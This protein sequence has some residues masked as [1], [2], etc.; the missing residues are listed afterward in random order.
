MAK[1]DKYAGLPAEVKAKMEKRDAAAV[2]GQGV[3]SAVNRLREDAL[4]KMVDPA[5]NVDLYTRGLAIVAAFN[6]FSDATGAGL[7]LTPPVGT[8]ASKKSKPDGDDSAAAT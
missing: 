7:K 8:K 6:E 1:F 2:K 3:V 4:A 5:A